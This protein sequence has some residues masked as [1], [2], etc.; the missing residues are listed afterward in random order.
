MEWLTELTEWFASLFQSAIEIIVNALLW[1]LAF[2]VDVLGTVIAAG[3]NMI[4]IPGDWAAYGL[5]GLVAVVPGAGYFLNR[6][7]VYTCIS[8]LG[9]ATLIRLLRK[10][11]T[12][13]QW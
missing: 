10:A 1:I 8:I 12:L 5:S 11:I 2:V 3:L 6:L 4:S 13:F 9:T 7:G